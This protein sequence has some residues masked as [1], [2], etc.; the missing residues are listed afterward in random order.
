MW[1]VDW[2]DRFERLFADLEVTLDA[3]ERAVRDAEVADRT[4]RERARIELAGRLC[5][6]RG[7][8]IDLRLVGGARAHG[9]LV[10]VG[11]DWLAVAPTEQR[12][13]IIPLAAITSIAGLGPRSEAATTARR[14]G[15]GYALREVS[16][17]RRRAQ[18]IDVV[19]NAFEG[20]I[21]IVG[22]D[23]LDLAEHPVDE[24]RR[25][26]NVRSIRTLPF[27]AIACVTS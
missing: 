27:A 26:P 3:Q 14:F 25:A 1:S 16:R 20:T 10:D 6:H 22:A 8:T 18:V 5:A 23:F 2:G 19:G 9:R 11:A 15:L 13:S 7:L 4:R 17:D 24:A 12:G 21:D